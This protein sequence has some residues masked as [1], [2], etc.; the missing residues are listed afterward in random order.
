MKALKVVS[1]ERPDLC[2]P[3]GGLCCKNGPGIMDPADLGRDLKGAV[4]RLLASGNYKVGREGGLL[5][6]APATTKA[7]TAAFDE[8]SP[9]VRCKLLTPTGCPLPFGQRPRQCRDLQAVD[10]S[11]AHPFFGPFCSTDKEPAF[12]AGLWGKHQ[13]LLAT[14][15]GI[16]GGA[17]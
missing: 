8:A 6:L 9:N 5:F 3:C 15:S 12:Y 1:N 4:K 7:T 2:G 14:A 10:L 17:P 16:E 11:R 13:D